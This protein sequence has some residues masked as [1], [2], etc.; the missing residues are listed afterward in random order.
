MDGMRWRR[1]EENKGIIELA[2]GHEAISTAQLE[3]GRVPSGVG[4]CV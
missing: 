3:G 2:Y 1:G 4:A